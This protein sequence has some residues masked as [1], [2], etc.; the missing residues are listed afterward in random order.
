M[1]LKYKKVV[2]R[3]KN[4]TGFLHDPVIQHNAPQAVRL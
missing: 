1:Y 2:Q 4:I 3:L